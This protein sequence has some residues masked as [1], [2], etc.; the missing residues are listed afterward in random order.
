MFQMK[1][2]IKMSV[3]M[4]M[5][6]IKPFLKPENVVHTFVNLG[7]TESQGDFNHIKKESLYDLVMATAF[8]TFL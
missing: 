5:W 6:V 7:A 8:K 1:L 3:F 4:K 2:A